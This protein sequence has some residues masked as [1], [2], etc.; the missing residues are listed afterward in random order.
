MRNAGLHPTDIHGLGFW[1]IGG[2]C[3]SA[4]CATAHFK[5]TDGHGLTRMGFWGADDWLGVQGFLTGLTGFWRILCL[6]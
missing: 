6:V 3:F 4:H 5:Y 2:A 1:D